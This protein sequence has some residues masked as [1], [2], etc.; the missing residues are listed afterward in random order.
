M[1]K[2]KPAASNPKK[3]EKNFSDSEVAEDMNEIENEATQQKKDA[4]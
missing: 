2:S 3:E 4:G 1:K